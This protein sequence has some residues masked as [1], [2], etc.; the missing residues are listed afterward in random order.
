MS[1]IK[2]NNFNKIRFF[3]FTHSYPGKTIS[4]FLKQ[5]YRSKKLLKVLKRFSNILDFNY[6]QLKQF[7]IFDIKPQCPNKRIPKEL[8]VYL[9]IERELSKLKEEKLDKYSTAKEDYQ[10]QLLYPAFERA[11]GNSLGKIKDDH[12][13]SEKLGI[14]INEYGNIYYKVA[15]KYKLP[16]IRIVPFLLRLIS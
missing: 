5:K 15:C 3:L 11:A 6:K 7:V 2:K 8:I 4:F 1:K 14:R 16:T 9:E 13:F 12:E 10:R